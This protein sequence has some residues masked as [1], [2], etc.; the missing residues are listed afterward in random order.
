ML[1]VW[2]RH[3]TG[4]GHKTGVCVTVCVFVYFYVWLS[5]TVNLN[6][7]DY[8][9][10]VTM[11]TKFSKVISK[12]KTIQFRDSH[13]I[14]FQCFCLCFVISPHHLIEITNQ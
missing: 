4:H 14:C 9:L 13:I 10:T 6:L 12:Y 7:T 5:L 1:F 2:T 3:M 11:S 8:L